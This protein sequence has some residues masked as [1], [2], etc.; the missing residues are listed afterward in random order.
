[1]SRACS[2]AGARTYHYTEVV[3]E[4]FVQQHRQSCCVPQLLVDLP[5]I[6]HPFGSEAFATFVLEFDGHLDVRR[7]ATSPSADEHTE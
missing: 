7:I 6:W 3:L 1:M 2:D 4:P 5:F